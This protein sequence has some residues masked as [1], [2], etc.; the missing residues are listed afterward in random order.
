MGHSV[1]GD[2]TWC[3][4]RHRQDLITAF[5]SPTWPV[6]FSL[7]RSG[8]CMWGSRSFFSRFSIPP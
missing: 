8:F 6:T 7:R 4:A 2:Y 1:C 5:L 3:S